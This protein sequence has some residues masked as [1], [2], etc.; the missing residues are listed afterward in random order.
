M[1]NGGK[2]LI[3]LGV[4]PGLATVGYGVV[5]Y[6]RNRFATLDY[7]VVSTPAKIPVP[8]RLEMIYKGISEICERWS[9]DDLAIEKLYFNTNQKTVIDVC[10][11]R[12]V[13]MLAAQLS[14]LEI[15]EYTPLQI[16]Q[17]IVGYGRAEKMQV[18]TMVKGILE[19]EK[20]PRPDDAADGLAVA[21]CHAHSKSIVKLM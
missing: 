4:D 17:A 14:R 21:I 20:L 3:I 15:Y 10:Q 8:V 7:G 6:E 9:P 1:R 13:A 5:K 12:G 19:L 16:K 18:M 2:I 11:A